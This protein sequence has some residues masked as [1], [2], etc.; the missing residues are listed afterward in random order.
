[1]SS[2]L[3]ILLLAVAVLPT[4]TLVI[5]PALKFR[6]CHVPSTPSTTDSPSSSSSLSMFGL[7][8]GDGKDQ[9]D[10]DGE[11]AVYSKLA[12]DDTVK[13]D[14]L[15]EYIQEWSKLFETDPKGMKLT[16]PVQVIPSIG[17]TTGSED[18]TG[19]NGGDGVVAKSGVQLVFKNTNTGYMS[20]EE[21]DSMGGGYKK[22]S[23]D[24]PK[25]EP[26]KEEKK[27]G[28]VKIL[29][30]RLSNGEIQVRAQRCNMD[31]DTMIKE[32]SEV[33]ILKELTKAIDVWKKTS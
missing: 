16:T 21:E 28:G 24:A 18:D 30:E 7:F 20:K 25:N 23:T 11:L 5:A 13:Y 19:S 31:E 22:A 33:T 9:K 2:V 6:Q 29:V 1:M 10:L 17:T 4:S 8:G 27:Q 3:M 12:K 26:K 32:M 15:S 14:S